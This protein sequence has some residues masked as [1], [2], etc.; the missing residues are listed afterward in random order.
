MEV[1]KTLPLPEQQGL[2]LRLHFFIFKS[3]VSER[4]A[5]EKGLANY[6]KGPANK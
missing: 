1:K 2:S 6:D 4:M 5:N 3:I